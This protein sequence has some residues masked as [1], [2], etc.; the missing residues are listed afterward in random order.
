MVGRVV[1]NYRITAQLARGGMGVVYRGRHLTLPREVVVKCIRPLSLDEAGQHELRARFRREAHIQSQLDHPHI[2]RVYEFLMQGGDD[3]LVLEYVDGESLRSLLDRERVLPPERV[4]ALAAQALEGLAHAHGLHF[5][6]E[7]GG[8]GVG[9][10]HRDIKPANLLLDQSGNL[11]LTDFGIARF[12][13]DSRLTRTGYVCGTVDYTSPEQ[14]R[15]PSLDGRSDL[16]SLGL[17]I[18]EALCGRLPFVRDPGTSDFEALRRRLEVD[19]P[20]LGALNPDVPAS[21]AAVVL[22]SL[23]RD[24]DQRWQTAAEFREAL[25]AHESG[26]RPAAVITGTMA[27]AAQREAKPWR[28]RV[29]MGLAAL[30]VLLALG[31]TYWLTRPDPSRPGAPLP[32]VAVLPFADLSVGKD[33]EH[34]ADGLAEELL[35]GLARTPG[36]RVTGRT[37]SFQFK[38]KGEDYRAI[39]KKLNVTAVLD[40]SVRRQGNRARITVQLVKTADGM[41]LWSD[42]Y[43]RELTDIFAVEEGIARAATAALTGALVSN[44]AR[45]RSVQRTAPEAYNAFLQG[46]YFMQRNDR[47]SLEKA[48]TYFEEAIEKDP[49][50]APAWAGLAEAR[51]IQAGAGHAPAD[52]GFS[53]ART[54]ADRAMKLNPELGEAH[55]TQGWIRLLYDW[56]WTGAEAAFRR[57]LELEPNNARVLSRAASLAR[58]LGR[59]NEAVAMARR[60]TEID[61][62]SRSGWSELGVDLRYAGRYDEAEAAYRKALELFPERTGINNELCLVHVGQSRLREALAQAEQEK[63]PMWRVYA[64]AIA[65]H[66]AGQKGDSDRNLAELIGTFGKDAP[67]LVA[68]VCAFRGE[69]DQALQWLEKAYAERDA[70]L[71]DLTGDPLL[72]KLVSDPRYAAFV[73]KLRLPM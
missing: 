18:Y 38:G 62:L 30:V 51:I 6:D 28:T 70:G 10:I 39:G 64:M 73:R 27:P 72:R 53:R 29:G 41:Q 37:S 57:A 1:G 35:N 63:S 17:T 4:V 60:A 52:E 65:A 3:F 2:V 43:D 49:A 50:Y 46:R 66:A 8:R 32:S 56:D 33:Q 26:G 71:T 48:V 19:A 23:R 5:V 22:R 59:L 68:E 34:L 42:T 7:D 11:K 16:F 40:G 9:I 58:A 25:L 21:L 67:F 31:G 15:G 45:P 47:Q 69:A 44:T 55:Y 24:P 36:L 13:S 54:A 12:D 14:I 61:P 20:A